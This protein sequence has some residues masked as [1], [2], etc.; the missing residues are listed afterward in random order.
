MIIDPIDMYRT[1]M[2]ELKIRFMNTERVAQSKV[3]INGLYSLDAEFCFLQ[4]RRMIELITFSMVIC[5]V[6]RYKKL[7]QINKTENNRDHGD[8]QKDW[9]AAEIL[10]KLS[11]INTHFLPIPLGKM[12]N[13]KE[14]SFMYDRKK[15]SVTHGR[16][17]EIYKQCGGYLHAKNPLVENF[18]HL[19]DSERKKYERAKKDINRNL[20]FIRSLMWKHV[21]I[22]LEWSDSL[23]PRENANPNEAW[24]VDFGDEKSQEI[25]ITRAYAHGH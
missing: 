4:I 18:L 23:D 10:K 16:L 1:H 17:I 20:Q 15:I 8:Y 19:V 2:V 25:E 9:E 14:S 22:G 11:E 21:A 3:P 12:T 5:D 7:R 13:C 6:E 24:V